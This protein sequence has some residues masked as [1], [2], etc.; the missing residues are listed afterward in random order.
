M[1]QNPDKAVDTTGYK[2]ATYPRL[3]CLPGRRL[4]AVQLKAIRALT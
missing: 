1:L 2:H 3:A 4:P